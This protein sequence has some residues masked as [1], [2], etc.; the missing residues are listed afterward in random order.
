MHKRGCVFENY[1]K[2]TFNKKKKK[3]ERKIYRV[4]VSHLANLASSSLETSGTPSP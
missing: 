2:K 1:I 4:N 3:K